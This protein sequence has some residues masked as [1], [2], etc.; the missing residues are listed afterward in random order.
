M[1]DSHFSLWHWLVVVSYVVL[2]FLGT[3]Y[4]VRTARSKGRR[5]FGFPALLMTIVPY[6]GWVSL[7]LGLPPGAVGLLTIISPIVG[8]VWM[9]LLKPAPSV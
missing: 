7:V 1:G 5:W 6:V 3:R 9:K 2:L 8:V 4:V